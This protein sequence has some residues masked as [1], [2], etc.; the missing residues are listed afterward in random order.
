MMPVYAG[1]VKDKI[2]YI[3]NLIFLNKKIAFQHNWAPVLTEASWESKIWFNVRSRWPNTVFK[4]L[5]LILH[6]FWTIYA[7]AAIFCKSQD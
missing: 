1:S 4:S 2:L 3:L 6:N 7:L 5:C